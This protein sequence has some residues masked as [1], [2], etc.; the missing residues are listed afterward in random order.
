MIGCCL[1]NM[2]GREVVDSTDPYHAD[3]CQIT[4]VGV[5]RKE[6]IEE[7]LPNLRQDRPDI[8]LDQAAGV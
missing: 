3:E 7:I 1:E 2:E 5:W 8:A 6:R 4:M